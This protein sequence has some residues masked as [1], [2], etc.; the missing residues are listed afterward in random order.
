MW[1]VKLGQVLGRKRYQA[2]GRQ[3]A[4]VYIGR[5]LTFA[6]FAIAVTCLWVDMAQLESL[7]VRLGAIGLAAA[8][9]G[10][11]IAAA[12][13]AVVWDFCAAHCGK[14]VEQ[15]ERFENVVTRNLWL[16]SLIVLIAA[17]SSFYH[18]APDFVYRAF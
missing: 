12:I 4:Y 13:G 11:A 14:L 15:L 2:L 17:V 18:K 9:I 1:Q 8:A 3:P 10:V 6:Y 7:V 5:G 16:A